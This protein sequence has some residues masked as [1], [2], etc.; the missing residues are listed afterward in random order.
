MRSP[1]RAL[2]AGFFLA[3]ALHAADLAGHWIAQTPGAADPQYL[4]VELQADGNKLTGAVNQ[5]KLRGSVTGKQVEFSAVQSDGSPAA[6]FH[7][8]IQANGLVG[9]GSLETAPG[10]GRGGRQAGP[11]KLMRA[12]QPPPGGPKTHDFE[13]QEYQHN[14]SAA[15]APVLH[16]FPG[17]T[18]RTSTVDS[19]GLDA[20]RVR[21][22]S[23]GN[24]QTGPFYI[25]GA[26]PGDTLVVKLNQVRL[27]RDTARSGSR[28]NVKTITPA[29]SIAAHYDNAFDSEWTLDTSK[30]VARLAHPSER[31]KG[32]TV[33]ILPMI[34]CLATAPAAGQSYRSTDLGPFGGNM[35]Y[36][37]MGE[38]M[39]LF[40]PVFQPGALFFLGDGHAAMGDGEL[41]GAALETSLHVE[42][43]VDVL[44]GFASA[45]PRAENADYLFS[46]GIAGS[47]PDAIQNATAQLATWVKGTY[48]LND[49]EVAVLFGSALKYDIAEMVDPQYNVVAKIPKTA[50]VGFR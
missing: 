26:L 48:R 34:G 17:D 38:G 25:E 13:P 44:P 33:P 10:G 1:R 2:L 6:A 39:T 41:T 42:F 23:G 50:L 20:K 35:D 47:I 5:W 4:R 40:L 30:G 19:G 18:V 22:A 8:E 49:N 11:W 31:M 7:G 16:V 12:V 14:Y 21:R 29:W 15:I 32:Y 46:M 37:L 36:N 27:N 9:E 45:G 24:P 3:A 28:I 43:T